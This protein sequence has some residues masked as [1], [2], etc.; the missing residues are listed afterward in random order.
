M[1][2]RLLTLALWL[3]FAFA[4]MGQSPNTSS[5]QSGTD[6]ELLVRNLYTLV[7]FG[8]DSLPAWNRVRSLF[9]E[10][11]GIYLRTSR[12]KIDS[13]NR[14]SFIEEFLLFAETDRIRQHG[15]SEEVLQLRS[16]HYG[17]IAQ[18]LVLYQATI[19]GTDFPPQQG[20][21]SFH[22]VKTAQGWKITSIVN[23]VVFPGD[24]IPDF[25]ME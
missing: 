18:V 19:P 2:Q 10:D 22:L 14:D 17:D 12:E 13:Y 8:P 20:I 15:F 5:N 6:A 7:T 1:I 9:T 3:F 4:G 25:F 11:A 23:E 21:D 16:M 24:P